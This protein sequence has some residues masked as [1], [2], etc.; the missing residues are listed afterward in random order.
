MKK[1]KFKRYDH[2]DGFAKG[3][4]GPV[5][6]FLEVWL[7]N[8]WSLIPLNVVYSMLRL[9]LIPG[10]LAQAGMAYVAQDLARGRHSFGIADFFETIKKCWRR[11]LPAGLLS[12]LIW[13]FLLFVGWFYYTSSGILA[14]LG[15]GCCL[16]A[17]LFVSLMDHY[18]WLQIVILK[19]PLGKIF[20]N[21]CLFVF[22]NLKKNLLLAAVHLG[23]F[24]ALLLIFML[25]PYTVTPALLLLVSV[26]FFPG[27]LN[28]LIQHCA[29]PAVKEHLIDPYYAEHPD[30]DTQK[31]KDMGLL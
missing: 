26:C 19:L 13:A 12:L 24:A 9:L 4:K 10:G 31:R 8:V 29:F 14:T 25:L 16:V 21:A 5:R 27:F 11:A 23:Y 17:M 1:K 7:E 3:P 6:Q 30:E 2:S 22:V 15:L 28:L 18:L 20:K